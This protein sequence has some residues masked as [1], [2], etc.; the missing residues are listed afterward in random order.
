MP[1]NEQSTIFPPPPENPP[2]RVMR[3]WYQ[4]KLGER[5]GQFAEMSASRDLIRRG[6]KKMQD[7][8][9]GKDTGEPGVEDMNIR[10]GDEVHQH[11][12]EAQTALPAPILPPP[13]KPIS[14]Q[15][16]ATSP[17]SGEPESPAPAAAEPAWKTWAKRAA[18]AALGAGGVAGYQWMTAPK[19]EEKPPAVVAPADGGYWK[20]GVEVIPPPEK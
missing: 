17:G 1:N 18:L 13:E 9:I 2:E 15:R 5:L 4:A 14:Q 20:Y 16:P 8:T 10:V 11:Y 19:P 12:H 7:G 6:A 3:Q